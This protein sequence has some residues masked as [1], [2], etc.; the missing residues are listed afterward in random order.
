MAGDE[1]LLAR[2]YDWHLGHAMVMVNQPGIEKLALSLDNPARWTSK[3]GSVT[4]NQYGR[5]LPCDGMNEQGLA[6]VVL[7][8]DETEYPA[9]DQ[10]PSVTAAQWLQ[11]QLDTATT[12]DE[13]IGSDKRLRITPLGGAT[14][15]YFVA[16]A[17]GESAVVEFLNGKMV[18]Q[19][20]DTPARSLI[21]NS[22]CASSNA[23]LSEHLKLPQGERSSYGNSLDRFVTLA[24]AVEH[25]DVGDNPPY[26]AAFEAIDLVRDVGRTR[27][28]LVCNLKA[29][30]F[31]FRT[32]DNRAIR[33]VDFS[34][35][36]FSPNNAAQVLDIEAP[37]SGD[38]TAEFRDYRRA[39]NEKLIAS[40]FQASS[41]VRNLPAAFVQLVVLYPETS[42]RPAQAATQLSSP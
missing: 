16:D 1:P 39:D 14:V 25:F 31:Y 32:L 15:H 9:S 24:S 18:V 13:V 7:W 5:E 33:Q 40:S 3:Y 20:G 27:W 23:A 10:R 21:T 22:T 19:R 34:K 26:H 35:L 29:R 8:L 6:I 12:V 4:I 28:Q 37:L 30:Q 2:N 11:Y 36:R 42:C 17:T 41:F 38:A